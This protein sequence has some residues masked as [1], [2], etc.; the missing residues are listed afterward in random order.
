ME[1]K[2]VS[3][4]PAEGVPLNPE[5]PSPEPVPRGLGMESPEE[6]GPL[7]VAVVQA[8][9]VFLDRDATTEKVIA[10][11]REA[12]AAGARVIAFPEGFVPG[13]PGWVEL[14]PLK[15]PRSLQLSKRLFENAVEVPGPAMNSIARACGDAEIAAVVGVCERVPNTT[16]TLYNAQVFIDASGT[17]ACKHQKFVPT[18]GE[19][20]V[21][22][23]GRTGILNNLRVGELTVTGLIC[24][25]NSHPLAQYASACSYP[26]IHAAAWP[27]HL[28]PDKEMQPIIELV[29]R[30]L[31]YSLKTFVCSSVMTI[32]EDMIDAYGTDDTVGYLRSDAA[33]GMSTVFAPTGEVVAQ[34]AGHEEQLL[35]ADI[36]PDDVIIPKFVHDVVGHYNRPELF[37]HLFESSDARAAAGPR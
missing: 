2:P 35:F 5:E 12:A 23:P 18:V 7:R 19:R 20:F 9:P 6:P 27:Q 32:G 22:A 1:A 28:S 31:A 37:A 8:A 10:I 29:S 34:A 36:E 13:H 26:T 3:P 30:G 16:G 15:D 21:H 33:R 17:I 14:L 4:S 24:G 11:V 25:E